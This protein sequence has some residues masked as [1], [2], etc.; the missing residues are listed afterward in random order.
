MGRS[1]TMV[2]A[3]FPK[4][5]M[6]PCSP[7][8]APADKRPKSPLYLTG[9]SPLDAGLRGGGQH[10]EA[11]EFFTGSVVGILPLLRSRSRGRR[12]PQQALRAGDPLLV[13]SREVVAAP[14]YRLRLGDVES[15]HIVLD[16]GLIA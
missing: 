5:A 13:V 14:A 1:Y 4:A 3:A 6:S 15:G 9:D 8:P 12:H 2:M 7:Q 16:G 10:D 11:I